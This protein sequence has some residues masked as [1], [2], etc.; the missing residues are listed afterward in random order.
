MIPR[1]SEAPHLSQLAIQFLHELQQQG[2][3]GDT[4]TSYAERLS[5]ATDNS[6]YQLLPHAV[7]FPRSSADVQIITRVAGQDKYREL[8]F[9]PRGGGTGTNGQSL[10]EG[11]VVDMIIQTAS[12]NGRA[13]MAFTVPRKSLEKTVKLMEG[14]HDVIDNQGIETSACYRPIGLSEPSGEQEV[15]T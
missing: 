9:T 5:M 13:D 11:I 3:T 1:I 15:S 4:G 8:S 7:I 2:F 14:L 12:R 10:T 6:I